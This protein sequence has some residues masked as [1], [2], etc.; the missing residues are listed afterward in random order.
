MAASAQQPPLDDRRTAAFLRDV[1]RDVARDDRRALSALVQYP[2]TVFAGDVR[3]PIRDADA[4][5][6]SY[7]VVFTPAM[8]A[9]IAR[10]TSLNDLNVLRIGQ[11][12]GALKITGMTVPLGE[13]SPERAAGAKRPAAREPQRLFLDV[14]RIRRAGALARGER[15]TFVLSARKNQ[16]LE[17]RITGVSGRDIVVRIAS[18]KTGAPIDERARDGLRTWI[19]RLPEDGDYR[20][21]VVRLAAGATEL[22]YIFVISMR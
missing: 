21:D 15:D 3:I 1:Q 19:G 2:L 22:P 10:A 12:G 4:F 18:V 9:A 5:A 14:G 8:K 20:I 13:T 6:Q 16:L 7:D 11:L 17:L